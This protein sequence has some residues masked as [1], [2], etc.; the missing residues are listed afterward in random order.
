MITVPLP[1]GAGQKTVKVIPIE[2]APKLNASM[3]RSFLQSVR[4][5]K[6][7]KVQKPIFCTICGEPRR[8]NDGWFLLTEN[9]GLID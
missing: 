1:G 7:W 2:E 3:D 5:V 4:E 8:E 9:P 6:K